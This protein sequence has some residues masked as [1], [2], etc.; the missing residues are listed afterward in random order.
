MCTE[1]FNS[2]ADSLSKERPQA[3]GR[4]VLLKRIGRY[5]IIFGIS[6]GRIIYDFHEGLR[7]TIT[8]NFFILFNALHDL[9]GTLGGCMSFR[10]ETSVGE[11]F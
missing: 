10:F 7:Q 6:L 11:Y 2:E 5:Q 9:I 4:I 1:N 8:C 3:G